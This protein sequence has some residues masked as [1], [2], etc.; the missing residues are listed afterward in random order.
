MMLMD[1][2][3]LFDENK[4]VNVVYFGEVVSRYDGKDSIDEFYNDFRVIGIS[5]KNDEIIIE[6][7][8]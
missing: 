7:M 3:D 2:I 8:D 4:V 5:A 1:M 6:V